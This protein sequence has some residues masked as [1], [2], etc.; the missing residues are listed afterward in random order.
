VEDLLVLVAAAVISALL[1]AREL[2]S[3]REDRALRSRERI[4]R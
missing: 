3:Q 2:R 1:V 4:G